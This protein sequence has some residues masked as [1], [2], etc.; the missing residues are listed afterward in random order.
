M[1]ILHRK[2]CPNICGSCNYQSL[3]REDE[4]QFFA[5]YITI[6][7]PVVPKR[8]PGNFWAAWHNS[9]HPTKSEIKVDITLNFIKR[10]LVQEACAPGTCAAAAGLPTGTNC[11]S[12]G[13]I[14]ADPGCRRTVY[15]DQYKWDYH[16]TIPLLGLS[17]DQ[18]V[19]VLDD[20]GKQI[21]DSYSGHLP[22]GIMQGCPP[23]PICAD[24]SD[25]VGSPKDP[26][27]IAYENRK[28]VTRFGSELYTV[29]HTPTV[30]DS[31]SYVQDAAC[32]A[33]KR[34]N[35]CGESPVST[36][37]SVCIDYPIV[38]LPSHGG[39]MCD[40]TASPCDREVPQNGGEEALYGIDILNTELYTSLATMGLADGDRIGLWNQFWVCKTDG[41]IRLLIAASST[42]APGDVIRF[43]NEGIGGTYTATIDLGDETWT[44]VM[45]VAIEPGNWCYV[46]KDCQCGQ[47][48][49]CEHH[50]SV[51]HLEMNLLVDDLHLCPQDPIQDIRTSVNV[52]LE[53]CHRPMMTSGW[54]PCF[55]WD[56]LPGV[57]YLGSPTS[58]MAEYRYLGEEPVERGHPYWVPYRQR[59]NHT[60]CVNNW[61]VGIPTGDSLCSERRAGAAVPISGVE[62]YVGF[63]EAYEADDADCQ[64][65]CASW[66]CA[67][68]YPAD[69]PTG[70]GY[71]WANPSCYPTR[72]VGSYNECTLAG[73]PPVTACSLI[74]SG[75]PKVSGAGGVG[76][77]LNGCVR[78]S[79]PTIADYPC[80]AFFGCAPPGL[81]PGIR[82]HFNYTMIIHVCGGGNYNVCGL[83]SPSGSSP[84]SITIGF[85]DTFIAVDWDPE[86]D[87]GPIRTHKL[88]VTSDGL[89]CDGP[90]G[91]GNTYALEV[92]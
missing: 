48:S 24:L 85:P 81:A 83:V 68:A 76:C 23:D 34:F 39:F 4:D 3:C 18:D 84:H 9:M 33:I 80:Q 54:D 82:E 49:W 51:L 65:G 41:R 10:T 14:A 25:S 74:C 11:A 91:W 55:M 73:P 21:A 47:N 30:Y 5:Q 64:A 15:T 87:C 79:V 58:I 27:W 53:T 66:C 17:K 8:Y 89:V 13:S 36:Q 71:A 1:T 59:Y 7:R 22:C 38:V 32:D 57:Q 90:S 37:Q 69:S 19:T 78:M 67:C 6:G 35:R 44:C 43:G 16:H 75:C 29:E 2:C 86:L 12:T 50:P 62:A 60:E 52:G 20:D 45:T 46:G 70:T 77:G 42:M 26:K 31:S 56:D 63:H 72:L 28:V 92:T 40:T 61:W 88:R